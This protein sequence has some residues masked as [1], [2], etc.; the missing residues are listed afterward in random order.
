MNTLQMTPIADGTCYVCQDKPAT[1]TYKFKT[2][3][4]FGSLFDLLDVTFCCCDECNRKRFEKW[5]SEQPKTDKDYFESYIYESE[6]YRYFE[7]LPMNAQEKIF[8]Q[9]EQYPIDAQDWIDMQLG[10]MTSEQKEKYGLDDE[11]FDTE[12]EI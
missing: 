5:F 4:G 9:G 6:M 8:N 7:S 1:H 2:P 11:L 10:E 3:R 12:F